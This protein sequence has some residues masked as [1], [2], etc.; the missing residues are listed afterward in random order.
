MGALFTATTLLSPEAPAE[1]A[2]EPL[3]TRIPTLIDTLPLRQIPPLPKP[4][5]AL[6]DAHALFSHPLPPGL[7]APVIPDAPYPA[8]YTVA[9]T[10]PVLAR[11]PRPKL[12]TAPAT[13]E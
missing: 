13:N 6:S 2:L 10:D 11:F 3:P 9:D 8:P 5:T 7:D 12:L 1:N 4:S